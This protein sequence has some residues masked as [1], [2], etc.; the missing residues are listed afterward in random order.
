MDVAAVIALFHDVLLTMGLV[1]LFNGVLL[2]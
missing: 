2:T 1:V